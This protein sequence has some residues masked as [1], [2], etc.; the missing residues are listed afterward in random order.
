IGQIEQHHEA[1][2]HRRR[3]PEERGGPQLPWGRTSADPI[4]GYPVGGTTMRTIVDHSLVAGTLL[5]A[6]LASGT[7]DAQ[8]PDKTQ[9]EAMATI[10][11]YALDMMVVVPC[12]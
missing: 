8:V 2:D 7:A 1:E 10:K 11:Q 4:S 6:A 5:C 9:R 12:W 3:R